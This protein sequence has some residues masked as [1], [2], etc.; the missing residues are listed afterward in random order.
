MMGLSDSEKLYGLSLLWKEVHY[1]FAHF[2]KV[3]ELDW[4]ETYKTYIPLVLNTKST[5]EYYRILSKFM[6]LLKDG[7]T[8]VMPPRYILEQMYCPR[9]EFDNLNNKVIVINVEESMQIEIPIGSEVIEINGVPMENY[10]NTEVFPY[11]SSSTEHYMWKKALKRLFVDCNDSDIKIKICTLSGE[12]KEVNLKRCSIKKVGLE[13]YYGFPKPRTEFK[14]L[15]NNIAYLALNT[16]ILYEV[17][18]DFKKYLSDI[19]KCKGLIIDLRKNQGG[20]SEI[21]EEI[22]KYFTDKPFLTSKWKSPK[23]IAAYK[24]W[25]KNYK[26]WHEEDSEIVPT[27]NYET[28]KIPIAIL[29]GNCTFSAAEDF[30]VSMDSINLA[31]FVGQKTAGSTG[32]PLH[33]KIPGGGYAGICSKKDVFPDGHEFVGY[34]IQP[35]VYVEQTLND[36]IGKSDSTLEIGLKNIKQKII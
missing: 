31:T 21:G 27:Y 29:T 9:V 28:I 17:L 12:N 6:A 23:Y 16:F 10:L 22:I 1:N 30:L 15:E 8:Y 14:I 32:S 34:G 35:H 20:H 36:I 19:K 26:E 5:I 33:I 3:P 18:D 25:N 7:H 11:V 13:K 4:D 24:S 2:D